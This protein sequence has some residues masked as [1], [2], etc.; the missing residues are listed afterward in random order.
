MSS[1]EYTIDEV[2]KEEIPKKARAELDHLRSAL[3]KLQDERRYIAPVRTRGNVI[4]FAVISDLQAGSLYERF[5]AL[6][7]FY[8]LLKAEKISNVLIA[9]DILEGHGIYKGQEF[10]IYAHG[11]QRQLA[12]LHE[13]FPHSP[14]IQHFFITGNHD[15]SFDKLVDVGIGKRI[16]QEMG[17]KYLGPDQGAVPFKTER[18]IYRV[19]LYHP[20]G[21]TAYAI[22]YKSQK[23]V[24]S[25]PGGKK[26]DMLFIG[27]Y[28]KAEWMPQYRNVETFQAGCFQ[29]Q[30][31][32]MARKP[33]PAH[34]GGWIIEVVMGERKGLSERVKA[35]FISFFEPGEVA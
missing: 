14:D 6:Q 28:H 19:G 17:W 18:G 24:E 16:E 20:S 34:I 2:L 13:K 15:Y 22:S 33:T 32:F 11:V 26:P 30:T 10:E 7:A 29:S 5:D 27:H 23:I 21:G 25:L 3:Q 12:V 8:D 9:G 1:G 4:R 35:E 31:P